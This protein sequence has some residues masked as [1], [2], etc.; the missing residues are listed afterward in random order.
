MKLDKRIKNN[1]KVQI[2]GHQIQASL[3]AL[4]TSGPSASPLPQIPVKKS[5]RLDADH[6]PLRLTPSFH[7]FFWHFTG[8][9]GSGRL[10]Q[11]PNHN[12]PGSA[13]CRQQE[14]S[15]RFHSWLNQVCLKL[16]IG[17][18]NLVNAFWFDLAPRNNAKERGVICHKT[19]DF[20]HAPDPARF[21]P[22]KKFRSC[23]RA[24]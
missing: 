17:S 14:S 10:A 2:S 18:S 12:P 11:A 15:S 3:V 20:S 8:Q 13:R 23:A 9:D 19:A 4:V 1:Q 5:G 24:G 21:A 6:V 7:L 22:I 16:R